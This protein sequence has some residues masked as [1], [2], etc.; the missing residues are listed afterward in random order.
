MKVIKA[1]LNTKGLEE[2]FRDITQE[3]KQLYK[4][5]F[6]FID[7]KEALVGDWE[8]ETNEHSMIGLTNQLENKEF[9]WLVEQDPFVS[10]YE[11]R[12]EFDRDWEKEEYQGP[13][14]MLMVPTNAVKVIEELKGHSKV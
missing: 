10:T 13:D 1:I 14:C 5:T 4:A 12:E 2:S 9:W 3:E 11:S 6:D 8:Q 7:G